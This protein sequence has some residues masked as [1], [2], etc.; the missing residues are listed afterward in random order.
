MRELDERADMLSL[1]LSAAWR[2]SVQSTTCSERGLL[3]FESMSSVVSDLLSVLVAVHSS[4]SLLLSQLAIF[5]KFGR[6]VRLVV[7]AR[8]AD[9]W[10]SRVVGGPRVV[11]VGAGATFVQAGVVFPVVC[12]AVGLCRFVRFVG[13]TGTG[14]IFVADLSVTFLVVGVNGLDEDTKSGKVV[15][16][17]NS[18]NFVP[19]AARK[20]IIEL[21][22]EGSISPIEFGGEL[23]KATMYLAT[24]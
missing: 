22:V 15:W 3:S 12:L 21:S 20:S 19:D 7:V 11:V 1:T 13:F 8:G 4:L 9:E 5:F 17:A 6:E 23:L 16:F 2:G 14:S 18:Y 10:L 24:F